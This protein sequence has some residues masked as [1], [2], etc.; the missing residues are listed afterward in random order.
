MSN[1]PAFNEVMARLHQGDHDAQTEVFNRFAK[2]LAT[3]ARNKLNVLPPSKTDPQGLV[4]SMLVSFMKR[5]TQGQFPGL[6]DWGSLQG[7]L[8]RRTLWR[9]GHEIERGGTQRHNY[10]ID[11]TPPPV[12][13]ESSAVWEPLASDPTVSQ[14]AMYHETLDWLRRQLDPEDWRVFELDAEGDNAREISEKTGQS[15]STVRRTL[16]EIRE[17]LDNWNE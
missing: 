7:L 4:D 6:V 14:I 9:C 13:D 10:W 8:I 5:Y 15:E 16:R 17:L 3:V 11:Q 12:T 2:R 1:D